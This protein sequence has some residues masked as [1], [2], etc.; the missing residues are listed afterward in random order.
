MELTLE[1][2]CEG[3]RPTVKYYDQ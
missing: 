3:R 2:V 1:V